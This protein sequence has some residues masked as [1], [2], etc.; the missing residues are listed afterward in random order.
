MP[1]LTERRRHR[2][3][4]SNDVTTAAGWR[5]VVERSGERVVFYTLCLMLVFAAL[6][7]GAME[8][9]ACDILELL[10]LVA[11]LGWAARAAVAGKMTWIRTPLDLPLA[12]G[13]VY[14]VARYAFSPVEWISRQEMLQVLMYASVYFLVTQHFSRRQRQNALLWVLVATAAGITAYGFVNWLRGVQMV[15]WFPYQDS[16]QRLRGTFYNPNH[17]VGYLDLVLAVTLAHLLWSGRGAA[18]RIVLAYAACVMIGGAVLAGSRGGY[19]T[20]GAVLVFV[21]AAVMRG[22]TRRWWPVLALVSLGVLGGVGGAY[23]FESLRERFFNPELSSGW[24]EASRLWMWQAA[25]QIFLDHPWF[26]AGP[27]IFNAIY[28][29]YRD[30]VDQHIPQYVHNDYLQALCDYGIAGF[31]LMAAL[32]GVFVVAAWRIHRRWRQR[33]VAEHSGWHWPYWLETDRAGRP[34]WLLGSAAAVIACMLHSA[35]DFHLH[36]SAYTLTLTVILAMGML[37]GHA[38][39]LTEEL[40]DG[41]KP[42]PPVINPVDLGMA[43]RRVLATLVV[44]FVA[45][46]ATVAVPNGA[47]CFW[48]WLAEKRHDKADLAGAR[49]AAERAWA[50][51]SRN[52]HAALLLGDVT[53]NE[54]RL[55]P[56]NADAGAERALHW[57]RCAGR[58]DPLEAEPVSRQAQALEF[59]KR[60]KEAEAAHLRALSVSPNY[61]LYYER[62]GMFHA[63]RGEKT[64]A[65]AELQTRNRLKWTPYA[66]WKFFDDRIK[67]LTTPAAPRR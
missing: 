12:A 29:R 38:R 39:R 55:A 47:S 51:D 22:V 44:L 13:V 53:L 40:P 11:L 14:V 3:R 8:P 67:A 23:C 19:V 20:T 16:L 28:G 60:W 52:H 6:A 48:Q 33:G 59:L 4:S 30:P 46:N 1:S 21:V 31:V 49:A 57:Y 7:L 63:S 24:F 64:K 58:L 35:V 32:V 18:Q 42:G 26:G 25:W 36:F 27:A 66:R 15:W 43:A 54:A 45:A 62:L 61:F 50:W 65:V 10:T 5:G 17:F 56:N 37:A 34:A 2:R 9:W 41:T